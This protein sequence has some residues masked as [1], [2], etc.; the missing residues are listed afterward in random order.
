LE[1][2]LAGRLENDALKVS[3]EWRDRTPIRGDWKRA[4]K[5]ER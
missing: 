1:A 3:G 5:A 2:S 4:A